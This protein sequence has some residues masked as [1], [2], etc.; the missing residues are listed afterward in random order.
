MAL[1]AGDRVALVDCGGSARRNA[2]DLAADYL[3]TVG[4]DRVDLLILTHYHADHANGVLELLARMEVSALA[5]PDVDRE[6]ALRQELLAAAEDHGVQV[7]FVSDDQRLS[8]GPAELTLYAP[9][10]AGD[11]NEAGLS[12]LF[13]G[14]GFSALL[15]GDMGEDIEARLVK[16][17]NLPDIDLLVVGHHGSRS[18][19]SQL[20]LETVTPE[21]AVISCGYNT[22]GHPAPETLGRLAAAGCDIYR[23]D[24]QGNLTVTVRG[25][26]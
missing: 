7:W 16:Y 9:L 12:V 3:G 21:A 4:V 15:T 8:F 13:Q 14:A 6:D 11:A 22:Y 17:G 1:R 10:G 23:T 2:G 5:V 24:Q 26:S 18:A 19:A 25:T 20:L